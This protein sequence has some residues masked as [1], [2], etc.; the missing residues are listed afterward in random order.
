MPGAPRA[1]EQQGHPL[2]P[3]RAILL[4]P[5]GS[6]VRPNRRDSARTPETLCLPCLDGHFMSAAARRPEAR[7]LAGLREAPWRMARRAVRSPRLL[8]SP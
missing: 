7:V 2:T 8:S 3:Q 5:L 1:P 4:G 6:P